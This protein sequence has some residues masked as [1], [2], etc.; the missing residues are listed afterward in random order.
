MTNAS[1]DGLPYGQYEIRAMSMA[2]ILDTG[3]QLLKNRFGLL[4]GISLIGQIPTIAVFSNFDWLLDPMAIQRGE[5]PEIGAAFVFA[6]GIYMLGMLIL[7]PFVIG[8]ITAAVGD[9]YLGAEVT[10][11]SA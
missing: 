4:A 8:S 5:L 2:E 10:F 3:F 6:I 7:M 11:Q 1:I 9:L